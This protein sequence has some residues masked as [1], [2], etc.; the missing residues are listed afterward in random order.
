MLIFQVA[1]V[2]TYKLLEPDPFFLVVW[3]NGS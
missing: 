2:N 1:G 3:I